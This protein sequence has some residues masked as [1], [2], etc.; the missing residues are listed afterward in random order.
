MHVP[1]IINKWNPEQNC[2]HSTDNNIKCIFLKG[3]VGILI[4]F[5]PDLFLRYAA[6]LCRIMFWHWTCD[7]PLPEPMKTE[8]KIL[9]LRAR[10]LANL[11]CFVLLVSFVGFFKSLTNRLI[12][13]QN[14]LFAVSH[15]LYLI[16]HYLPW[17]R[18]SMTI[19]NFHIVSMLDKVEPGRL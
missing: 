19:F 9:W 7:K 15:T 10:W 11:F 13:E 1:Q 8:F 12:R 3:M 16:C 2:R 18:I 6:A 5:H 14:S 17:N 4:P